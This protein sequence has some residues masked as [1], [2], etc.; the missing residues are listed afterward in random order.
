MKTA[1]I[2]L[3]LFVTF[4]LHAQK[5]TTRLFDTEKDSLAFIQGLRDDLDVLF[6][7]ATYSYFDV[8][9]G[10]GNYYFTK[11]GLNVKDPE[12][13]MVYYSAGLGYY[14]KSGFNLSV[15]GYF[16]KDTKGMVLYQTEITP[17]FDYV[18]G[19]HFGFGAS[20]S[21]LINK[22]S[23]SF[24]QTP[25]TNQF[26][27]Y[28]VYKSKIIEP[29][30]SFTYSTGKI[31]RIRRLPPP[32]SRQTFSVKD[33]NLGIS[34]QHDFE[35]SSVLS[36]SDGLSFKPSL[37]LYSGSNQYGGLTQR[38]ARVISGDSFKLQDLIITLQLNYYIGNFYIQPNVMLDYYIPKEYSKWYPMGGLTV[39]YNF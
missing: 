22:D 35:F 37:A 24:I 26:A 38:Q 34:L 29:T 6:D 25:L 23:V 10:L 36:K 14:H 19:K 3:L 2:V 21:R 30:V 20:Y 32:P 15:Q 12:K 18:K 27:A 39:G 17:S 1:F 16:V 9:L 7:S 8:N 33:Y 31:T 13:S 11:K 5:D 4:S 28:V